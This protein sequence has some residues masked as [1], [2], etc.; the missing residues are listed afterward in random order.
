MH[1]IQG[2][3]MQSAR[4]SVSSPVISPGNN[5]FPLMIEGPIILVVQKNNQFKRVMLLFKSRFVLPL[6][7]LSL[8]KIVQNFKKLNTTIK[9]E[10]RFPARREKLFRILDQNM[11]SLTSN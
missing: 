5:I 3:N 1:N 10:N 9:N 2:W 4:V 11:K 7:E 8:K 6:M